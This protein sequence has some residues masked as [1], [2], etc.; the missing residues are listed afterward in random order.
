MLESFIV[1]AIGVAAGVLNSLGGGGTFVALPALVA[2]GMP[3][4]TANAVSR[5]ALV[6]GALAGV[7]VYRRELKPVGPASIKQLTVV[8][9]VGSIVGA[10]LL[11]VLPATSFKVLSP[12]LLAFA[13]LVLAFGR[14]VSQAVSKWVGRSTDMSARALLIGQFFIAVYGG[15]FG[16]ALGILM[17]ALWSVG[18]GIDVSAANPMRITQLAAV[19]FVSGVLFLFISDALRTPLTLVVL[20]VGATAGG[21]IGAHVARRLPPRAMRVTLLTAATVMTVFYFVRG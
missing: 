9:V 21:Y 15:Y 6:P 4:V 3:A 10:G 11:L 5:I 19:F 12:W 14:P 16:G 8:S 18:V 17:V 2:M 20:L 13:T 1:L 7:W